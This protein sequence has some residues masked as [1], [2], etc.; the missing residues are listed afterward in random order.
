VGPALPEPFVTRGARVPG[1]PGVSIYILVLD[2]TRLPLARVES[3]RQPGARPPGTELVVVANGTTAE[4]LESLAAVFLMTTARSTA[5]ASTRSSA[6]LRTTRRSAPSGLASCRLTARWRRPDRS[7][8]G[9]GPATTWVKG[10]PAGFH[11]P[12]AMNSTHQPCPSNRINSRPPQGRR[13][14]S[15][16]YNTPDTGVPWC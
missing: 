16:P 9:T 11:L 3:L 2:R 8:G 7:S 15:H 12:K 1:D 13:P 10:G 5:G 6:R 4:Q 14:V